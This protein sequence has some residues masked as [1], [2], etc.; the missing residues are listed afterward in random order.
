MGKKPA[1]KGTRRR[2]K[3]KTIV[4]HAVPPTTSFGHFTDPFC[5][6]C[7]DGGSGLVMCETCPLV[8][9]EECLVKNFKDLFLPLDQDP[10][11]C[12]ICHFRTTYGTQ[13][14]YIY[15]AQRFEAPLLNTDSALFWVLL[16]FQTSCFPEKIKSFKIPEQYQIPTPYAASLNYF[17]LYVSEESYARACED[18]FYVSPQFC[19]DDFVQV[20]SSA[21][22][23][24]VI[25][26]FRAQEIMGPSISGK[27]GPMK[28][29]SKRN[30]DKVTA[31][32]PT[33]RKAD[34]CEN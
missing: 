18:E 6:E 33:K 1:Y 21:L 14:L 22:L 17:G 5:S 4:S 16:K 26:K 10:W 20:L 13:Q 24:K 23:E 8:F 9:H 11:H 2:K 7:N 30:F 19:F 32:S 27:S 3:T 29:S 15:V 12:P 34:E 25:P 31:Y 28:G